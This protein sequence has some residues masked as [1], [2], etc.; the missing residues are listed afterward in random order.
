[1]QILETLYHFSLPQMD[2]IPI[3]R[4]E[5]ERKC[6]SD[7]MTLLRSDQE[8]YCKKGCQIKEYRW[9]HEWM[10]LEPTNGF[11]IQ[12]SFGTPKSSW[13][14]RSE[15]LFKKLKIEYFTFSV[16]SL[17]GNVGGTLGMFI[18]FSFIDSSAW[19]LNKVFLK[20]FAFIK[21]CVENNRSI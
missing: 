17:V 12:Y 15:K 2:K 16:L 4:N 5:T 6:F 9:E 21:E 11:V 19:L 1:M 20:L 18:G 3:C 7:V 10:R 14:T 13:N 8:I